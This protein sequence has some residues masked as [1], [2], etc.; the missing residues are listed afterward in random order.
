MFYF[1][2]MFLVLTLVPLL[3]FFFFKCNNE[4]VPKPT[5][6]YVV[7]LLLMATCPYLN[8]VIAVLAPIFLLV[9]F[10]AW[11]CTRDWFSEELSLFK[12]KPVP[13]IVKHND[14]EDWEDF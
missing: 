1:L 5:N 8:S 2:C 13:K 4:D 7:V 9:F 11:V 6:G 12:K 14:F 3:T 10:G